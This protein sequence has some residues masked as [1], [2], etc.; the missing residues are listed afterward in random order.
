M[1]PPLFLP[2]KK[3]IQKML[4]GRNAQFSSVWGIMIK[5]WRR[6]SLG[7]MSKIEQNQFSDSQMYLFEIINL[8]LFDNHGEIYRFRR[9]FNK[10]SGEI[11]PLGVHRNMIIGNWQYVCSLVHRNMIIGNWQYV[12]FTILLIL[13]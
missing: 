2:R 6:I 12:L 8:K 4:I 5:T 9:K 7:G 13:T 1:Y 3:Y 10:D 11:K